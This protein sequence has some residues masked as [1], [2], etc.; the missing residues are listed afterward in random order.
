MKK[1]N[2]LKKCFGALLLAFFANGIL[3]QTTC[4]DFASSIGNWGGWNASAT[5]AMDATSSNGTQYLRGKDQGGVSYLRNTND[6]SGMTCGGTICWRFKVINDDVSNQSINI[7]PSVTIYSGPIGNADLSATFTTTNIIVTENS[8]WVDVCAPV[9]KVSPLGAMPNGWVMGNG[10]TVAQW[11]HLVNNINGIAFTTDINPANDPGEIIGIDDVCVTA[12]PAGSCCDQTDNGDFIFQTSCENGVFKVKVIDPD[13]DPI[14]HWWRLMETSVAGETSD[15]VTLNN[16][17]PLVPEQTEGGS[18]TFTITDFSKHY[19]IK[20]DIMGDIFNGCVYFKQ[21]RKP[22]EMPQADFDFFFSDWLNISKTEFC[23][24]ET[25]KMYAYS[26]TPVNKYYIDAWRRPIGSPPNTPFTWYGG[27]G[28]ANGTPGLIDLTTTFATLPTPIYFDPGYE[29][30]IKLA[31]SNPD[32]CIG[33]TEVKHRFKVTCCNNFNPCFQLDPEPNFGLKSNT[34]WARNFNI[35]WYTA[36]A[37]HEWYVLSSP[38]PTGG[39]YTLV[40]TVTSTSQTDVLLYNNAQYGVQYKVIHKLKTKCGDFCCAQSDCANCRTAE[41]GN[42]KIDCRILDSILCAAAAPKNLKASCLTERFSWDAVPGAIGYSFEGSFNNP[43]CCS[44]TNPISGFLW[45]TLTTNWLPFS[46][47]GNTPYECIRWRVR[48]RCANGTFGPWSE[49]R[50]FFNCHVDAQTGGDGTL[51]KAKWSHG[52]IA[53][54]EPRISPNPN[55]GDMTLSLQAPSDLI[56]SID[57]VN[58]Q[59]SRVTSIPRNTYK[60]G[61]FMTKLNLGAKIGKGVYTIVFNTNFGTF[62]K[63]VIVQ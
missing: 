34:L 16:G 9:N 44:S 48:A 33:W 53:S 62:R 56:L 43:A 32:L 19:Y 28:W 63:K 47:L 40:N 35:Y 58:A 25:I 52:A 55:N 51:G 6:F 7:S 46:V 24:G 18:A 27:P 37:Q 26:E 12:N 22:I 1:R 3:A 13:P 59:G 8:A 36:G 39:P 23:F 21:V 30:E 41:N 4:F 57:V 2:L 54:L 14:Y 49:Y 10:G 42:D 29:Y 60:G 38:N 61:L 50:C 45:N 17:N 5:L 15:A 11:N 31:L 20:H